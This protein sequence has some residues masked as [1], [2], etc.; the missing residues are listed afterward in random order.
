LPDGKPRAVV[1][2]KDRIAR[3]AVEEPVLDHRFT[4][5]K[6]L[7]GRL[8]DEVHRPV[9]IARFREVAGGP[10]EHR[11]VPV[12]AASMHSAVVTR[13]VREIGRLLDRQRIHIRSQPHRARRGAGL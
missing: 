12:M 4:A 10:E 11:R 7:F 3:K 1:H 8:E 5:A 9:E 6:P 13:A 2:A